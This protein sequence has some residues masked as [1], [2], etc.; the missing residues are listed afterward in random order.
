MDEKVLNEKKINNKKLIAI[1]L[2]IVIAILIFIIFINFTK[3]DEGKSMANGKNSGPVA[4]TN[5]E[6]TK[7][8]ELNGLRFSNIVLITDGS[9]SYLTIDVTNPTDEIIK[10]K[11]VDIDLKDKSGNILSTALGYFGEEVPAGQT[12]TINWQTEMD[13]TKAVS[14]D[15][16]VTP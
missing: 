1:V 11:S 14:K 12:R 9:T 13:L 15:V 16:R 6:I 8:F 5:A 3:N 2:G 10:M 4:N 7:E